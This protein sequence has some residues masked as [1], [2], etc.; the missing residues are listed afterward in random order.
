MAADRLKR[1]RRLE[2]DLAVWTQKLAHLDAKLLL[3]PSKFQHHPPMPQRRQ[4]SLPRMQ[5]QQTLRFPSH[6]LRSE[7]HSLATITIIA[8]IIETKTPDIPHT[9]FHHPA[10]KSSLLLPLSRLWILPTDSILDQFA[11]S[12][13]YHQWLHTII[14]D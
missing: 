14:V 9:L 6:L 11:M 3:H 12:K 7:Q 8:I 13:G 4:I 10:I 5:H 2:T 1:E